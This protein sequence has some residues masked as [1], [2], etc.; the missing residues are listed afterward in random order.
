MDRNRVWIPKIIEH[1]RT[2]VPTLIAVGCLHLIG[3]GSIP[4]LLKPYGYVLT[5]V[6]E[7]GR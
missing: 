7:S 5:H 6:P 2:C 3:S 4:E 1:I